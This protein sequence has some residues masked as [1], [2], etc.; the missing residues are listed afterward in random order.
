MV[1]QV[2]L[3]DGIYARPFGNAVQL[4]WQFVWTAACLWQTIL[5]ALN[6]LFFWHQQKSPCSFE[7]EASKQ[8]ICDLG[9][10]LRP[11]VRNNLLKLFYVAVGLA[12]LA[13]S[14][15]RFPDWGVPNAS[16]FSKI[17]LSAG[18][19][20]KEANLNYNGPIDDNFVK[21]IGTVPENG[22]INL[23][24][25]G[26][27]G[28]FALQ[29]SN[30]I[31]EKGIKGR[32]YVECMSACVDFLFPSF[33][34]IELIGNPMVGVHGNPYIEFERAKISFPN[35]FKANQFRSCKFEAD[36]LSSIWSK[37]NVNVDLL[38]ELTDKLY[39]E[40]SQISNKKCPEIKWKY[41]FWLL[42]G[43]ELRSIFGDKIK[44]SSCADDAAP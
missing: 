14:F 44:G 36:W 35:E 1:S 11:Q 13:F 37:N 25:S 4:D 9:L 38:I 16:E 15:L 26:G 10:E 24:S 21:F 30:L 17:N 22:T 18:N 43:A 12:G 8:R 32:I 34:Q 39:F 28:I 5:M 33:Q 27:L 29:A 20:S 19:Q 23:T 7:T 2:T 31:A 42:S 41:N 6:S 40:S 3:T